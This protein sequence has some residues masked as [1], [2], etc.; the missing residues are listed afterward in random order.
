MAESFVTLQR[1][2]PAESAA[3]ARKLAWPKRIK[4]RGHNS[5]P[6]CEALKSKATHA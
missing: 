1:G 3:A 4:N 5:I 6:G 2:H